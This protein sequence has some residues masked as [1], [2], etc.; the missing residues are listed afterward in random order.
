MVTSRTKGAAFENICNSW[1]KNQRLR[2]LSE[3]KSHQIL[4][5][6]IENFDVTHK[7]N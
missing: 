4:K 2:G 3:G 5:G 1:E 6:M 7:A